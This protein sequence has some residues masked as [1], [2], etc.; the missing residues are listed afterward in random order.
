MAKPPA[1]A[2]KS[3]TRGRL[4]LCL[5]G[6]VIALLAWTTGFYAGALRGAGVLTL[7][8]DQVASVDYFLSIPSF[9][10]A[11]TARDQL[12]AAA[13]QFVTSLGWHPS[14]EGEG[15]RDLAR[16]IS[17]LR[18]G[19]EPFRGTEEELLLAQYL[20]WALQAGGRNGEWLDVYLDA[21]YRHPTHP[22][23]AR[24]AVRAARLACEA[25]RE[26]E[27]IRAFQHLEEVPV[28]SGARHVLHLVRPR[29]E[30][31]AGP[32]V[33]TGKGGS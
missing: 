14:A 19:L 16:I 27:M 2:G 8:R 30:A 6:L 23:I 15:G 33:S 24:E 13:L 21:L 22:L 28:E 32:V 9:S 25:R 7:K 11:E 18:A 26:T 31:A 4:L 12:R 1:G 29:L 17:E 20:L 10:E 5:G 3:A